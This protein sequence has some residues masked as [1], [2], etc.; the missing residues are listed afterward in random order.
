MAS[1]NDSA[2]RSSGFDPARSNARADDSYAIR[3]A[4]ARVPHDVRLRAM[5]YDI[6]HDPREC[7][8]CRAESGL[9]RIE[10]DL[11]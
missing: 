4:L 10:A 8:R 5:G 1:H 2:A 6:D 9:R 3:E 11:G 7:V